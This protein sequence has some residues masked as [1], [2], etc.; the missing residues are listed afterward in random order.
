MLLHLEIGDKIGDQEHALLGHQFCG[1]VIDQIAML[2]G[3]HAGMRRAR[4]GLRRIG[5]R[6]DIAAEGVRFLHGRL[7]LADRELQAVERVIGRGDAAGHHDLDL[8]A[9][10]AHFLAHRT[11]DLGDAVGNPHGK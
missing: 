3:A 4:N 8:V 1:G 5:V 7:H 2:D 10:L 11:A 6:A 9:A